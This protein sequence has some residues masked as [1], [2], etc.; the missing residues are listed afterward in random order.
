M[1][2]L[3]IYRTFSL[4]GNHLSTIYMGRNAVMRLG[5]RSKEEDERKPGLGT[6]G[7]LLEGD[8]GF[9]QV[10]SVLHMNEISSKIISLVSRMGAEWCLPV[11]L[12]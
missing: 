6:T 1:F 11:Y 8:T 2:G 9:R 10:V 5:L 3:L 4:L 12:V 7:K